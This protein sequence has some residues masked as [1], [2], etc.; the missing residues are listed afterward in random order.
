MTPPN[1]QNKLQ[2][3][4]DRLA[5]GDRSAALA[6]HALICAADRTGTASFN[7]VAVQYRN[8]HLAALRAAGAD[9]EREAGRLSMDEVRGNLAASVLPRLA[10]EQVV[11]LPPGGLQSPDAPVRVSERVWREIGGVR[12]ELAD[13][14]KHTGEHVAI[15]PSRSMPA[16]FGPDGK[17]S[18]LEARGLVKKYRRRSVV[19]DVALR[20]QQGEIV[21]LLGPNGA[22]K[23]TTFYMIVGLIQPLSGHILLDGVD[24]TKMPMYQRSRKGI[25]Y[26]SQEPSIFRKLSVEDNIVA[27]LETLPLSASERA[28]RL[29]RLL[30][31]LNIKHLRRSKAYQLS[32]GERRRLEITRALVT[33]PKFMMLDEP[34]A[35][36]DPIAVHDIQTIVADLR[37]RGIG[38]LI[39]DHNVEQTLDIVDRAYIM[40]DG[41]VKVSGTVR[42]LVFDET[43]ADIYLGPTLSARLRTRFADE[44]PGDVA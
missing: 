36:V 22:G 14:L 24:V 10:S 15:R 2:E 33:Q 27:I 34:F 44:S 37:H 25:G 32:G 7:D 17:R 12:A 26:L 20:L 11:V 31:E 41:Q 13:M 8:D 38:V 9:A 3:L 35:G 39:S 29:E 42:E 16:V 21:G 40:F 43:V 4:V 30:D 23:T 5:R 28:S 18:T 19:N 6:L 1:G